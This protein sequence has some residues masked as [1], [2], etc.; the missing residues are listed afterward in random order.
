MTEAGSTPRPATRVRTLAVLAMFAA[1][2][3]SCRPALPASG[4]A[5][6]AARGANVL[7]VT[8]DTLRRDRVG[9]YG[10]A[11][12]LTP[13]IDALAASGVRYT[14]AYSHAPMTLPAHASLLTGRLPVH[15]G[16]RNNSSYRL[17]DD[18][19][20]LATLLKGQG[21]R[22]GA[23]VGAFV[24]DAR[25][26]LNR[27]F[28][29]Y[30]DRVPA[31]RGAA[32]FAFPERP[33]AA[34]VQSA[35][36]WILGAD[37]TTPWLA[38]VHLFDPHA[39]YA[40]PAEFASGRIPYDGE[41]AYADAMVG[42]LVDRLRAAGLLARTLVVVTADHGESLGEHGEATHG[43]FAYDATIAVPLV[44]A[45]PGATASVSAAPVGHVD[46]LPTVLAGLGLPPADG[47]DGRSLIDAPPPGRAV[48]F[49][50]LDAHLTRDWAPLTGVV[51]A[52]WKLIDLPVR[53]LYDHAAD[54]GESTNL[55]GRDQT[56]VAALER[57]RLAAMAAP[58]T[59][60]AAAVDADAARRLRA[61]GY[62][63]SAPGPAA[64]PARAYTPSDDPKTLVA[65]NERF[66]T[67]LA[68]FAAGRANDALA[69]LMAL[70]SERPDFTTARTSAAAM[71]LS[72]SRA[73]DAVALLRAAP[74]AAAEAPEL[75]ARLGTAYRDT[76]DLE[77]ARRVLERVRAS[78]WQNPEVLNDLGVVYARLGRIDDARATFVTLLGQ[79]P[80]AADAW[81]NL[82][83][84]ELSAGRAA[85]AA[86]AFRHAVDAEPAFGDAWQGL[87]AALV[88][89]D[90]SAAVDAW[91]RAERLKPGD[92]DLLYNLGMLLAAGSQRADAVPYLTR[93]LRD[94][95]A[96]RRA[97]RAQ[98]EQRLRA[99]AR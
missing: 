75:L 65:L 49:E 24:L 53:E 15:H 12:G 46:V 69:D 35:G 92:W 4:L 17:G 61:L 76:G 89:R 29:V 93:F 71:L 23:F 82:G 16:L 20:T 44:I 34:V 38:W 30:D 56:M 57:T 86:E 99:I 64:P 59:A 67:A 45:G 72:A 33:G 7:L 27:G 43:L 10:G 60:P 19:P 81:N 18:V 97:D 26:G 96:S 68:A 21:Y 79:A 47:L 84:L 9:A 39:P 13:A 2:G 55:A 8:I 37:S 95:P 11:R 88:E 98:V 32:R 31:D 3:L 70:V 58:A 6:G 36:D 87:G 1:G 25:F 80:A 74:A 66:N 51:T 22:T 63:A 62:T 94:A 14:R 41:V 83:V 40:A 28:D 91:R 5:A 48:Y 42:R 50:A 54:P 85:A 77:A 73:R 78:G 52:Q 90:P